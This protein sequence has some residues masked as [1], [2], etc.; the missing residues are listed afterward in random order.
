MSTRNRLFTDGQL[1]A[2][3]CADVFATSLLIPET[4][5]TRIAVVSTQFP[6]AEPLV[7][8]EPCTDDRGDGSAFGC[9]RPRHAGC[10][11]RRWVRARPQPS[12]RN[13]KIQHI[14]AVCRRC[15]IYMRNANCS[16]VEG[17]RPR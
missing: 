4:W 1:V 17:R 9:G 11:C 5:V 2:A 10:I 14:V 13:L 6:G 7:R 12:P 8:R 3:Q 15:M 16:G